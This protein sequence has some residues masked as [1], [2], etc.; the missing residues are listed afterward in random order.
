MGFVCP[1]RLTT[2]DF[3]TSLTSASERTPRNGW[4][5]PVPH[6][7]EQFER[8]WLE[9]DDH[10]RLV[11]EID[12]CNREFHIADGHHLQK[13]QQARKAQQ[14]K[15]QRIKS[16]YTI[17]LAMQIKLCI[18][19][20]FWRIRD[21]VTLLLMGTV[22]NTV[23]GLIVA[24]VLYNLKDD[25]SALYGRAALLF[26]AILLSAFSSLLEVC[27]SPNCAIRLPLS[28]MS[29]NLLSY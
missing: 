7:P 27:L 24:S 9:S 21:D 18:K 8:R 26:F 17:S 4:E 22:G 19:R 13:F 10:S 2:A 1:E 3:L 14:A 5:A 12:A 16:P 25:I 6:A 29:S 28:P 20:S 15:N 11:Q 23:W